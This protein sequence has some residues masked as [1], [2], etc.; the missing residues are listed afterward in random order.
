MQ[1]LPRIASIGLEAILDI[2]ALDIIV[3]HRQ[4]RSLPQPWRQD[5]HDRKG[6]LLLILHQRNPIRLP[7]LSHHILRNRETILGRTRVGAQTNLVRRNDRAIERIGNG[8]ITQKEAVDDI[9]RPIV[10]RT[11][12]SHGW[13]RRS[14]GDKGAVGRSADSPVGSCR[15]Q[16]PLRQDRSHI[17]SA[18]SVLSEVAVEKAVDEDMLGSVSIVVAAIIIAV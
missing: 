12:K 16:K 11:K 10:I 8:G 3:R 6:T 5:L 18:S 14:G 4:I 9:H 15:G 2:L 7:P 17:A 13:I 1:S